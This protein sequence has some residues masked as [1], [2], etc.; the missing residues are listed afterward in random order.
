MPNVRNTLAGTAQA[1][2]YG[3]LA[4]RHAPVHY[5]DTDS[6]DYPSEYLTA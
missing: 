5:Q 2:T 6:S 1:V 4:F 3:E